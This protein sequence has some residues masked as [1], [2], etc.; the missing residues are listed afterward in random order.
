MAHVDLINGQPQA[1]RR[2]TAWRNRAAEHRLDAI[3]ILL[4]LLLFLDLGL[5][6]F[7]RPPD[8]LIFSLGPSVHERPLVELLHIVSAHLA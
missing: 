5:R 3:Y 6:I 4:Q 8:E 1:L 7:L 2:P